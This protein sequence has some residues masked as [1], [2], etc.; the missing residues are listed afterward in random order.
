MQVFNS[1]LLTNR[2]RWILALV[3]GIPFTLLFAIVFGWINQR[4]S[5]ELEILYIGVGYIIGYVIQK[6]GRGVEP[7]FSYL[8]V[9]LTVLLFLISDAIEFFGVGILLSPSEYGNAISYCIQSL[10]SL[11]VSS[12]LRLLFRAAGA[13]MAYQNARFL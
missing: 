2:Q 3:V 12:L 4:L 8:A 11:N 13:Y 1:Q 6:V 10:L 5:F 9:I 7:K